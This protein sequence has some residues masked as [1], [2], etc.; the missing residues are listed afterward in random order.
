MSARAYLEHVA[1]RVADPAPHIAFFREVLG[2][3]VRA[4]DGPSDMPQQVWLEGGLQLVRDEAFAGGEGR[5]L[6]LGLMVDDVEGAIAAARRLG[7]RS[8]PR[9]ANWLALP[10]G[11][12]LELQQAQG[13]AVARARAIDPRG[14]P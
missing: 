4:I 14:E 9:G 3:E 10:D 5:F 12:M 1:I 11:L 6:H 2:M 8:L 7:A 13:D